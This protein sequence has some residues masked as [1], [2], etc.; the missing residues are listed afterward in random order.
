LDECTKALKAA[1]KKRNKGDEDQVE[2]SRLEF[3]GGMYWD[4]T[5]GPYIP[6]DNL[7]AML[8]EGARKRK[9]GKQ[10]EAL[11]EVAPRD[12]VDG[13][14]IRYPGPRQ[15]EEMFADPRFVF[16]KQV[17][18]GQSKV[19]RTRPRF[20]KW[21]ITFDIDSDTDAGGPS[22]D[23]IHQALTDAGNLVGLGD[24]LPRYGRFGVESIKVS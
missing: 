21:E 23:E 6:T 12:D 20:P 7:Q 17:R 10:F 19:M 9:L 22:Q 4:E 16:C 15:I 1:A 18:V 8:V 5:L 14:A 11:V 13:Y 3:I 24:W 2:I